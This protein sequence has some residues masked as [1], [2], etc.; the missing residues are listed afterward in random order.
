MAEGL[1]KIRDMFAFHPPKDESVSALHSEV[2][3]EMLQAAAWI[4]TALPASRE[5][6]IAIDKMREAMFWAN[7]AIAC[8]QT[9]RG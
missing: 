9:N 3:Q 8:N 7:A 4:Y 2:R 1:E 5:R 6:D